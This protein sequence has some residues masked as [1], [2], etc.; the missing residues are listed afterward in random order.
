MTHQ[1]SSKTMIIIAITLIIIAIV[2]GAFGAHGLKSMV[3][4]ERLATWHTAVDYMMSQGLGLLIIS[5]LIND[6][7]NRWYKWAQ[8]LVFCGVVIFSGSL[9]L[10]VLTDT[11]ILGAITPIGGVAMILGWLALIGYFVKKID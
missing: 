11:P 5:L 8:R 10:M 3:T 7:S 6:S 2:T 1:Q 9:Y 4:P